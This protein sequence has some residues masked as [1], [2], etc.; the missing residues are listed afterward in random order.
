MRSY[1]IS[2][3]NGWELRRLHNVHVATSNLRALKAID[4]EPSGPFVTSMLELKLDPTTMFE[5]QAKA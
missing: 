3:G 1:S 5:W 4:Y 2:D